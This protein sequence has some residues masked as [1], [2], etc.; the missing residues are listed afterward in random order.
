MMIWTI[1]VMIL[2]VLNDDDFNDANNDDDCN[3]T[4]YD[5][6][7]GA[8]EDDDFN[9]DDNV[10]ARPRQGHMDHEEIHCCKDYYVDQTQTG[11]MMMIMMMMLAMLMMTMS[12]MSARTG[13]N[14][15][16]SMLEERSTLYSGENLPNMY[17]GENLIKLHI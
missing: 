14:C 8:N 4:N 7:N 3:G 2:M 11:R 15:S 6:F 9:G 1:A 16:V 12:R 13:V 10:D 5:N 17:S